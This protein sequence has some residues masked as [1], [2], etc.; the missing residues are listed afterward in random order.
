MST[1]R[2]V[3]DASFESEVLVAD[4]PVLVQFWAE[5]CSPCRAISPVVDQVAKEHPELTVLRL[6]VDQNPL[7]AAQYGIA[8]IPALKLFSDGKVLRQVVGAV[9][10]RIL[11]EDLLSGIKA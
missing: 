4:G 7:T 9:P 2:P 8:S 10:K 11:E 5:W 3:T 6:N 1:P